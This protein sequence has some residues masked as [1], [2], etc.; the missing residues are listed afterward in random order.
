M[1]KR[2]TNEKATKTAVE[3]LGRKA[4]TYETDFASTLCYSLGPYNAERRTQ[5][6]TPSSA[7][8]RVSIIN[9]GSCYPFKEELQSL[10]T[11][12]LRKLHL[13]NGQLKVFL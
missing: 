11:R 10:S 5:N 1:V 4:T 7:G 9:I 2:I 12:P 8:R 3:E 6:R 13:T